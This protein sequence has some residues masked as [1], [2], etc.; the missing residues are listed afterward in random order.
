MCNFFYSPNSLSSFTS[1]LSLFIFSR[2]VN[3]VRHRLSPSLVL[4]LSLCFC[5][6]LL[7]YRGAAPHTHTRCH[8]RTSCQFREITASRSRTLLIL[9]GDGS[10]SLAFTRRWCS[11][12]EFSPVHR[13]AYFFLRS[14]FDF[15]FCGCEPSRWIWLSWVEVLGHGADFRSQQAAGMEPELCK[16]ISGFFG[17]F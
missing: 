17:G 11:S 7:C 5:C 2:L 4:S 15:F 12:A 6:C 9:G 14:S 16:Q 3:T 8:S 1:F 13:A 10:P